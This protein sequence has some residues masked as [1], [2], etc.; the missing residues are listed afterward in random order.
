MEIKEHINPTWWVFLAH[1]T[2]DQHFSKNHEIS[3]NFKKL[4]NVHHNF[5][6]SF[7]KKLSKNASLQDLVGCAK[8]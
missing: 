7:T 5:S 6:M 4:S 1:P 2:L 3:L 8:N